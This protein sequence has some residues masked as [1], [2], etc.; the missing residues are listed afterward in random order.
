MI[1]NDYIE[2]KIS[3]YYDR[4]LY[5]NDLFKLKVQMLSNS[6][7]QEYIENRCFEYYK[8]SCSIKKV[9]KRCDKRAEEITNLFIKNYLSINIYTL[10]FK[11]INKI[12][13]NFFLNIGRNN[14]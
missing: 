5:E 12:L 11:R 8:I 1:K 7:T 3:E 6:D 14:S 9:K 10:L 4:E 13:R 2:E